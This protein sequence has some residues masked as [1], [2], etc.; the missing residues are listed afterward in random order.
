M[1]PEPLGG[2]VSFKKG[3]IRRQTNLLLVSLLISLP[4]AIDNKMAWNTGITHLMNN[5]FP[6]PQLGP[7]ATIFPPDFL[8]PVL[9]IC[10]NLSPQA[11]PDLSLLK[12]GRS[13]LAP[14]SKITSILPSLTSIPCHKRRGLGTH[15]SV[16]VFLYFYLCSSC[17]CT[18]PL[19]PY[20]HLP[21]SKHS[22]LLNLYS[23]LLHSKE[24]NAPPLPMNFLKNSSLFLPNSLSFLSFAI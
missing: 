2:R 18:Y 10:W 15:I 19:H 6:Q 23:N 9:H 12:L 11:L 22:S 21:S 4:P 8:L 20:L 24:S 17:P 13:S 5:S 3:L 16:I 7:L 14:F 1:Y